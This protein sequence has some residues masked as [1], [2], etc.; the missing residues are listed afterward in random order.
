MLECGNFQASPTKSDMAVR[1][2]EIERGLGNLLTR[3]FHVIS[4]ISGNHVDAKQVAE[5]Q[6]SFGG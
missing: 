1:T 6:R 3:Q 5:V 2:Y 4:G